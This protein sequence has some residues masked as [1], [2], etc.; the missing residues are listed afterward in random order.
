MKKPPRPFQYIFILFSLLVPAMFVN[1]Q[2]VGIGTATPSANLHVNGS[3]K[4]TNGTE[5]LNKVL[6]SDKNGAAT[7]E[8]INNSSPTGGVGFGAWGDC[9]T[10]NISGYN[11]V[12]D[13]AGALNGNFG[14]SVSISGNYAIIGAAL[15]TVG[16]NANQGA[17]YIYFYDGSKWVQEQM[18]TSSDA[19]AGDVFGGSVSIHGN[20]A[21]VGAQ[22]KI[23]GGTAQGKAYIY[24]NNGS[25]WE[26]VGTGITASDGAAS[27]YFGFSVS[28][29]GDYAIVGA[30]NKNVGGNGAQGKAY[31]FNNMGG[32]WVQVGN[33]ITASDGAIND[34]FGFSVSIHGTNAIVGAHA[35]TVDGHNS[36]GKAYIFNYT[37]GNWVQVSTGITASDGAEGDAFGSGV[38]LY[39]NY[40]IVG[41]RGKTVMAA[42]QGA[43]YIYFYNGSNWVQ[44]QKLTVSDGA[45]ND[46]FGVSMSIN[47]NYALVGAHKKHVGVNYEQGA[48]YIY[49]NTGGIWRLL[50]KVTDPG[51]TSFDYFGYRVGISGSR[52]LI[53]AYGVQ[54][55][56]G[57]AFF[58]KVEQ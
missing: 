28:I 45:E 7:W 48:A 39:E 42:F 50:Q 15:K 52:F 24:Y 44:L 19:A 4:I 22:S 49:Q 29:N 20:Y 43:A 10:R 53:G 8:A 56:R 46:A 35:K 17:A 11:P 26:Q 27:D 47:G 14:G 5:G 18:L 25:S 2:N 16:G 31:I 33:G 40:A 36:Q 41:A 32:N 55:S 38:S 1:A 34:Q 6:T 51:G 23:V 9:S 57:M 12:L 3:L 30:Y 13:S 37:G 54:G 58:G 21:I